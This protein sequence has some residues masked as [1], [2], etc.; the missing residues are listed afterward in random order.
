MTTTQPLPLPPL[1]RAFADVTNLPV[2]AVGPSWY[3]SFPSRSH[4][5]TV[6]LRWSWAPVDTGGMPDADAG[7]LV[8]VVADG[9]VAAAV[10][11]VVALLEV[12]ESPGARARML[13][14]GPPVA[15]V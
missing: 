6:A 1:N 13:L 12:V 14:P 2:R 15:P 3:R 5:T 7:T 8:A 11:A 4:S 9:S 10:V